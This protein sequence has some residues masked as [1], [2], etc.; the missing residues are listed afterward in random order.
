MVD[1]MLAVG[2]G[3]VERGTTTMNGP[4]DQQDMWKKSLEKGNTVVSRA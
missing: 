3:M 4:R 2:E 1:L